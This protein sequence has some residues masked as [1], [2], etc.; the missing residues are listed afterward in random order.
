MDSLKKI[1]LPF[2]FR[3]YLTEVFALEEIR[4][5]KKSNFVHEVLSDDIIYFNNV[6]EIRKVHNIH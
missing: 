3:N 6:I 2:E 1:V 5:K 4:K